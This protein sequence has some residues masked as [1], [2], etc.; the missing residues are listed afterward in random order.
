MHIK[1]LLGAV[2]L[3]ACTSAALA[4]AVVRQSS[5]AQ[6][7]VLNASPKEIS[8][9]FNEKVEKLFTSATLKD[10]AGVKV[11]VAKA[12]IDVADP[13]TLRL[14]VPVLKPGK[15]VV[16]WTAVGHDGHRLTGTIGFSVN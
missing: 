14:A 13:S 8:I 10:A 9:T 2:L 5:P 3:A 11:S 7:A 4:H 15:Y 1:H 16:S 6:G 12:K